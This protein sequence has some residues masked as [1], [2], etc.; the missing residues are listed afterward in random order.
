MSQPSSN[1]AL[2]MIPLGPSPKISP[3]AIKNHLS[4]TWSDIPTL[5]PTEKSDKTILT[6]DV[7]DGAHVFLSLMPGPIPWSDLEGPCA[8]SVLWRDAAKV[9]K[10]HRAHLLVTIMFKDSRPEIQKSNLLTQITASVLATCEASLGVYWCN[11]TL[12]V[13]PDLFREFAEKILPHGPPIPIWVDFRIGPNKQGKM[14]GFTTGLKALGHLEIETENSPEPA[15]ELRQRFEGLIYYL[16]ENGPV[17]K[18]GDTIGEDQNERIKAVHARSAFGHEGQV[19]RL[20]YEPTKK[21]GWFG[22]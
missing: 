11:A 7:G 4:S 16:L 18:N 6:F 3:S 21:K 9:L 12:V 17:I 5:G 10:P 8:T 19:M 22:R 15:S 13:Q 1:I 20:D 14:S 2:A